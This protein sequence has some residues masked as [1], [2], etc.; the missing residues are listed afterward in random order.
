[1]SKASLAQPTSYL[2][3]N[4]WPSVDTSGFSPIKLKKFKQ[5]KRALDL[6]ISS[7]NSQKQISSMTGL[8]ISEIK[9]VRS[10]AFTASEIGDPWG[11]L[12]CIPHLNLSGYIKKTSLSEGYAGNFT[13]FL[14]KNPEI[15]KS[16][17]AIALGKSTASH[18]AVRGKYYKRIHTSFIKLCDEAGI[19][20]TWEYPFCN[21]DKGLGAIRDYCIKLKD[22]HFTQGAKVDYG[23][24]VGC[25]AQ[26][27]MLQAGNHRA[28][29]PYD[30]VQLDGH[31]IDTELTVKLLDEIGDIQYLP[32]SRIW[33]LALIDAS[34]RAILGYSLSLYLNYTLQDV[35]E[36][37]A[38]SFRDSSSEGIPGLPNTEID[39]CSSRIFDCI[40]LD[41]AYSHTSAWLQ[42]TLIDYGVQEV[43]TNRPQRPR[44]NAIVE[45]FFETFEETTFHQFPTTTGNEPKDPRNRKPAKAAEKLVVQLED[46]EVAC[47]LAIERYNKCPH[48]S[49]NGRSPLEY[50]QYNINNHADFIRT[51]S[52][53]GHTKD[54]LFKRKFAVTIRGDKSQGHYPYIQFKNAKYTSVGL[55]KSTDLIGRKATF[56]TNITD[57][58]K[59][60][61]FLDDGR[62]IDELEVDKIWA[63]HKHSLKDRQ[64]ILKLARQK[65]ISFDFSSPVPAF[66]DYLAERSLTSRKDRN[67]HIR[68]QRESE[69]NNSIPTRLNEKEL[70]EDRLR[71]YKDKVSLTKTDF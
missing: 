14:D 28:Y 38:S 61:L 32:L 22:Q 26:H 44:S 70:H 11:Y 23:D 34:S 51:I 62:F 37:I 63:A 13:L 4:S 7:S 25:L 9:R 30:L 58:R 71:E 33:I 40:K 54:F 24:D 42:E 2:D 43:I 15:K 39:E 66:L 68:V 41:N 64:T 53:S 67:A 31:K 5:R 35:Q 1:M 56:E 46:I 18:V 52:L 47:Q 16:L 17:D 36:C 29:R 59:G 21:Q 48:S 12:A 49:L 20:T 69:I 60:K 19:D 57:I 10:R 55:K 8:S 6:C 27:S 50:V 3:E 65:K 45:R